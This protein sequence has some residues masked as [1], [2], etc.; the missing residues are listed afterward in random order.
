MDFCLFFPL[1]TEMNSDIAEMTVVSCRSKVLHGQMGGS[2]LAS[3]VRSVGKTT[4]QQRNVVLLSRVIYN[5][6]NLQQ[7][8]KNPIKAG[9]K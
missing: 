7:R 5:K 8:K 6:D 1:K 4:Q 9:I 2:A 3:S